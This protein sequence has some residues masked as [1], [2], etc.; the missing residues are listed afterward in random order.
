M[1]TEVATVEAILL[2]A[3][4]PGTVRQPEDPSGGLSVGVVRSDIA[5]IGE[6]APGFTLPTPGGGAL[7][8]SDLRGRPVVLNFFA[9]WCVPCRVEMPFLQAAHERYGSDKLTIL[10][11][12]VQ[13]PEDLVSAYLDELGLTFPV[14]LDESGGQ[15]SAYGIRSLPT[16]VLIDEAGK[17]VT[18]HRGV[19]TSPRQLDS[20][21]RFVLPE[22]GG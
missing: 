17:V 11:I 19:F 1:T 13:E 7:A 16:T 14:V 18:I 10:G 2:T 3:R 22:A 5:S 21:L 6:P 9:T 20:T 4:G 15:L 12:D 8:L